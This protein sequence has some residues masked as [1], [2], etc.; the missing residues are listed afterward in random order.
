MIRGDAGEGERQDPAPTARPVIWPL[1]QGLGDL[2]G[3]HSSSGEQKRQEAMCLG[4]SGMD[5]EGLSPPGWKKGP[6]NRALFC[7]VSTLDSG[8]PSLQ[9]G[10]SQLVARR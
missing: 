2:L 5:P 6:G 1:P 7:T 9:P 10:K 4:S 8:C 3:L